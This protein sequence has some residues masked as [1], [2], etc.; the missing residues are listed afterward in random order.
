MQFN[1]EGHSLKSGIYKILSTHTNR[2]YIGQ[3]KRFKARWSAHRNS[4]LAGKHQNKFFQADFNKSREELGH[5]DFLEFHVLEVMEGSTKEERNKREEE[6]IAQ[7]WDK[8]DFCYNFRQKVGVKE[9]ECWSR[10]P[11]E[12]KRAI[13]KALKGRKVWNEGV[14]CFKSTRNL[15][16]TIHKGKHYSPDTE[17]QSGAGHPGFG[18]PIAE[19]VKLKLSEANKGKHNLTEVTRELIRQANLGSKNH[20]FGKPKS[21]EIKSK[22]AKAHQY[23]AKVV[24]QLTKEGAV[25]ALHCSVAQAARETMVERSSIIACC[26]GRIKSCGGFLWRYQE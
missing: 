1:Y 19:A 11:E 2:I 22:M 14:P 23:R 21:L 16:K 15:L 8:Q 18:K 25:I 13:S 20:N 12:T 10:N 26:K 9:R 17:F 24:E 5:D 3:A 6:W 4:L 7:H